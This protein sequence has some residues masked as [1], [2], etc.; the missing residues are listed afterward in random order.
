MESKEP[1]AAP[2]PRQLTMALDSVKLRGLKETERGAIIMLLSGLLLE[3]SG[4]VERE[5]GNESV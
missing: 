2:T 4:I 5:D 1:E 3:A